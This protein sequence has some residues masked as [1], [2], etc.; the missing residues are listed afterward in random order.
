MGQKN[1]DKP[2]KV[3][4]VS[5]NYSQRLNQMGFLG[6]F[7]NRISNTE[8]DVPKTGQKHGVKPT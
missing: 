6:F 7:L 8:C 4:R 1:I 3:Q 2:R 5:H